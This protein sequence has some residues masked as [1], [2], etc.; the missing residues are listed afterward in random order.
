MK[1]RRHFC[2]ITDTFIYSP[3]LRIEMTYTYVGNQSW[4][5]TATLIAQG[6]GT[7]TVIYKTT[8]PDV[9][10]LAMLMR[11]QRIQVE[12]VF[13]RLASLVALKT[14]SEGDLV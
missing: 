13:M 8:V 3:E 14:K 10:D 7:D 4:E 12:E 11:V 6:F 1:E 9:K 2:V 5:V